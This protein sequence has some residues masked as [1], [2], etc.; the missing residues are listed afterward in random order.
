MLPNSQDELAYSLKRAGPR[1]FNQFFVK[2]YLGKT[3]ADFNYASYPIRNVHSVPGDDITALEIY[4]ENSD[5]GRSSSRSNAVARNSGR[6]LHHPANNLTM[7]EPLHLLPFS[8]LENRDADD[9]GHQL[10]RKRVPLDSLESGVSHIPVSALAGSSHGH[11]KQAFLDSK[12][13]LPRTTHRQASRR[14][15]ARV[16]S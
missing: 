6:E 12:T 15:R 1:N 3:L 11:S 5:E 10:P 9:A 14:K 13:V 7:Q 2:N 8:T 4:G 16:G